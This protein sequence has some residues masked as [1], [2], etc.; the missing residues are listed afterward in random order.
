MFGIVHKKG[1]NLPPTSRTSIPYAGE[2]WCPVQP[3]LCLWISLPI[4]LRSG[5]CQYAAAYV[6][7]QHLHLWWTVFPLLLLQR[8]WAENHPEI[9]I[10][11]YFI[12]VQ[13]RQ[14]TFFVAKN[15][16]WFDSMDCGWYQDIRNMPEIIERLRMPQSRVRLI[17]A[18]QV[19]VGD[20]YRSCCRDGIALVAWICDSMIQGSFV[21]ASGFVYLCHRQTEGCLYGFSILLEP[22]GLKACFGHTDWNIT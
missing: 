16:D 2:W 17:Q 9:P 18:G 10:L 3:C 12:L 19:S 21:S 6:F 8:Y 14:D 13:A 1:G 20:W 11:R 4:G 22:E 15:E 5:N 7:F